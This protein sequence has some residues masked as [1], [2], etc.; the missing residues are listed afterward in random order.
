ME[1]W[2]P[3]TGI[4]LWWRRFPPWWFPP[5][6]YVDFETELML[7]EQYKKRLEEYRKDLEREISLVNEEIK[8]V[9]NRIKELRERLGTRQ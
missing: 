9:E 8:D 4:R 3:R 1:K 5:V 6:W 2:P 7:L